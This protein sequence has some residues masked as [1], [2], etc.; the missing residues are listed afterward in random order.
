MDVCAPANRTLINATE[1]DNYLR[2]DGVWAYVSERDDETRAE[3]NTDFLGAIVEEV[4]A[5]SEGADPRHQR[6]LPEVPIT[7]ALMGKPFA[8][9]STQA[10]QIADTY[11]LQIIEPA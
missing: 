2:A 5:V 9:K 4:I 8:G 11:A 6:L 1:L 10:Q 3:P 7:I